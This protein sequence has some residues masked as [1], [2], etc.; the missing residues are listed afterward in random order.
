VNQKCTDALKSSQKITE[1]SR[2][3]DLWFFTS[4][5]RLCYK[6][7]WG[8]ELRIDPGER[9]VRRRRLTVPQFLTRR[10]GPQPPRSTHPTTARPP[11]GT[12]TSAGWGCGAAQAGHLRFI[13]ANRA[14]VISKISKQW[15][16][17]KKRSLVKGRILLNETSFL[18]LEIWPKQ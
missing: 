12:R 16:K 18:P 2:D 10:T 14:L 9:E 1:I 7:T 4:K 3:P 6:I 17:E 5:T 8:I 15:K 11:E 13:E